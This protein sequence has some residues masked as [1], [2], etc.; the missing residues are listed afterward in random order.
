MK[1]YQEELAKAEQ[2][3][4]TTRASLRSIQTFR[5]ISFL[6][7]GVSFYF[8]YQHNM[9][10]AVLVSLVL[11]AIFGWLVKKNVATSQKL[12]LL[13]Q[14]LK[15]IQWEQ[16][17]LSGDW[18][19]FDAGDSFRDV[20]HNYAHDLD[21]FGKGSLYQ[22]LNRTTTVK[23]KAVLANWLSENNLNA[24]ELVQ[25][26][27]L[28][29]ELSDQPDLMLD[30]QSLGMVSEETPEDLKRL[31]QWTN[32]PLE[33]RVN[34]FRKAI[35][36]LTMIFSFSLLALVSTGMIS[37]VL[38]AFLF[39]V[40]MLFTGIYISKLTSEYT[41]LGNQYKNLVK[42]ARLLTRLKNH[43]LETPLGM[44]IKTQAGEGDEAIARLAKVMNAF[45]ARNNF[46]VAIFFNI[47]FQWDLLC[48]WRLQ[49]WHEENGQEVVNWMNSIGQFESLLSLARFRFNHQASTSFPSFN[50][51][52]RL[53]GDKMGHPFIASENR[54]DNNFQIDARKMAI[55]TGANMAGKSTFLRTLGVNLILGMAGGPVVASEM[56]FKPLPL[57]SSMR[58]ADSLNSNESYFYNEL[59]RL[60]FLV[61]KLEKGEEL[62]VI[63][64]EILKGTNSVDKAQGSA[65]FVEKL[66]RLP[67]T[68]VIA[69]HDL[70]LC[71]LETTYPDRIENLCFDVEI[72][73]DDLHF[74]YKLRQGVCSNMN[75]TFLMKKLGI[76]KSNTLASWQEDLF[77]TLFYIWFF[78]WH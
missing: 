19:G 33:F 51:E 23:G 7:T 59:K 42:Y 47:Y 36:F 70:S 38:F 56:T 49:K 22:F 40:P 68:G 52:G 78:S 13:R 15:A 60:H 72:H 61:E 41:K 16:A 76:G 25:R 54:I 64:D 1:Y 73:K 18:S 39:L 43:D 65:K 14:R 24:G 17:S 74:D 45:D 11:I 5:V 53:S 10:V 50:E 3:I 4:A 34:A 21:L 31:L 57:Y 63:L 9:T 35:I 48:L 12:D 62:F 28:I 2:G 75:A 69:T 44:E 26:Q 20:D 77:F 66:L 46:L 8:L 6:M 58:T 32:E 55:I 29:K 37:G 27:E 67:V 30:V 71:E